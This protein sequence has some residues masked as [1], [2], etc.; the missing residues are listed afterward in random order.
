MTEGD[1]S[2][3]EKTIP[4]FPDHIWTEAKVVL[5]IL[6]IMIAVGIAGLM[7]PIG[8]E[9]PADPM[10]TPDHVKSDWYFLFLYEMLKY[11]P[12]TIGVLI[13]IIGLILIMIW[14]FLDR[15]SDTLRARRSRWIIVIVGSIIVIGLTIMGALS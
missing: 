1:S 4:F 8:L 13:P 11:V 7:S 3:E 9:A 10:V 12:K 14:P 6:A 15:K 5:V 2:P